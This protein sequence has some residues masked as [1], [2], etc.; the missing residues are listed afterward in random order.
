MEHDVE[1][2]F[3][4]EPEQMPIL[5]WKLALWWAAVRRACFKL[6]YR[7]GYDDVPF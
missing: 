7:L 2:I 5:Q 1:D 6:L 3:D 4:Q